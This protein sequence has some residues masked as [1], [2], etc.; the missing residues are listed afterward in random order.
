MV[1]S[2]GEAGAELQ[3]MLADAEERLKQ[4]LKKIDELENTIISNQAKFDAEEK[5]LNTE[6]ERLN[7]ILK[8]TNGNMQEQI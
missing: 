7:N 8:A 2:G 4:A 5:R 1:A 3:R 6:I